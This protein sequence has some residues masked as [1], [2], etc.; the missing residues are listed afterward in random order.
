MLRVPPIPAEL[1][2][3]ASW[4]DLSAEAIHE[5]DAPLSNL[6]VT[7]ARY[8]LSLALRQVVGE[9]A[10]ANFHS[11]A[12]W[13]SR[14]AGVT[15]REE[16][17]ERA[18]FEVTLLA[19]GAGVLS[20]WLL[21]EGLRPWL[22]GGS[23]PV[24]SAAG[25]LAGGW[26]GRR[27]L[28]YG[29][30]RAAELM[31]EGNRTVLEDIGGETARFVTWFASSGDGGPITFDRFLDGFRPGK[32]EAD[33]QDL[34]ISEVLIDQPD[35]DTLHF[36]YR[37]FN[38]GDPAKVRQIIHFTGDDAFVWTVSLKTDSGWNKIMEATWHRKAK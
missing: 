35:K 14:K 9:D 33:G 16:G 13:G 7:R 11:R 26:I 20:G 36:G 28:L 10:G 12:V 21:A 31:L 17:L 30:R 22:P 37:P 4:K 15:I 1:R 23:V 5:P 19:S 18:L 29:R 32:T 6:K 38:D 2:A 3:L 27:W 8:L 25:A 24:L 34:N